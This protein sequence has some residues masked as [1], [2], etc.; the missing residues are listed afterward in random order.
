MSMIESFKRWVR[1]VLR[2][3]PPLPAKPVPP[4]QM[5]I[6]PILAVV[7]FTAGPMFAITWNVDLDRWIGRELTD[8]EGMR[9]HTWTIQHEALKGLL[10]RG[11]LDIISVNTKDGTIV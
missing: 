7:R 10:D 6:Q 11:E 3:I 5:R 8:E 2:P 1:H 9:T 4:K